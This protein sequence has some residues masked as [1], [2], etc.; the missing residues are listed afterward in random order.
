[1]AD[2]HAGGPPLDLPR[3]VETL[4]R[5]GVDYVLVGGIAARAHGAARPTLDV[6]C[7]PRPGVENLQR[8][9][10]AMGE[11]GARLAV[12]GLPD[13]EA[14]QLPV[15]LDAEFLADLEIT[16]WMTDAGGLDVLSHIPD[17][18]G[19]RQDYD[20]LARNARTIQE[21]GLVLRA[22]GLEEIIASKEW[23]NRPKDH[24]ALGELRALRDQGREHPAAA[25]PA[26]VAG[27]RARITRLV[28]ELARVDR[29]LKR[30]PLHDLERLERLQ[31]DQ[32]HRAEQTQDLRARL[33]TL[34]VADVAARARLAA[35]IAAS[36]QQHRAV[37]DAIDEKVR[38]VGDPAHVR[39][40]RVGLQQDRQRA[41]R[42]LEDAVGRLADREIQAQPP[43]VREAFGE[44]PGEPA[45]ARRWE[46]QVEKVARYR[47]RY[48]LTD[49][50]QALDRA[51]E[52]PAGRAERQKALGAL[53]S[54]R[55]H[56]RA[57]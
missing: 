16:T 15:Q 25:E 53:E 56:T 34:P 8:L 52:T 4:D 49:A 54:G 2:P 22:A 6:D 51:Q 40:H 1:M 27:D 26:E 44:R 24:A 20:V 7:V 12:D 42:E 17:R 38:T 43:W 5:H 47:A 37:V 10:A 39:E 28:D 48:G 14:K 19:G 13:E 21:A 41:V 30:L 23:A 45:G 50:H 18:A 32:R 3:L 35:A 33:D 57:R 29:A 31:G 9:A 36:E 11:L 55:G 46:A